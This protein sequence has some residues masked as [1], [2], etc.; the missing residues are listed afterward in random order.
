MK[1]K[2]KKGNHVFSHRPRYEVNTSAEPQIFEVVFALG[3]DDVIEMDVSS[4]TKSSVDREA[5]GKE[6]NAV[7]SNFCSDIFWVRNTG[8]TPTHTGTK[9]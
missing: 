9:C 8:A 5:S 7:F 1:R 6:Y 3:N 4:F 2:D